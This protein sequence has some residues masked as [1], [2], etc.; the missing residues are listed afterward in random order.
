MWPYTD[1]MEQLYR[2][3]KPDDPNYAHW[4]HFRNGLIYRHGGG[5]ALLAFPLLAA[6]WWVAAFW[7]PSY[8]AFF[9]GMAAT[10]IASNFALLY[11][12][13]G[14]PRCKSKFYGNIWDRSYLGSEE[15]CKS[16]GLQLYAPNGEL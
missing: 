7:L 8:Y 11:F 5:Y 1:W 9:A 14:C 3:L 16:C 4:K 6:T 2:L 12:R 10:I 15:R 13:L